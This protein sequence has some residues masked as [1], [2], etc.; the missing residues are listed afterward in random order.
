M[1]VAVISD[2]HANQ[3]ALEA[4]LAQSEMLG[5]GHLVFLGDLVGYGPDPEIVTSKVADLVAKGA[6][7]V[8]GNHDAA[9]FTPAI[10]MND[11]A[12]TAIAWTRTRLGEQSLHFLQKLPL[13]ATLDDVLLVHADASDPGRW[14]YVMDGE[15]ARRSLAA[16]AAR[17]TIC[18][19][20]HVPQLYCRTATAKVISHAPATAV[21]V[22]L[23]EQRQ[24][25]AVA[26]ACGQPR[27]GNPAAAFL[28]YDTA[29]RAL[30]CRRAPYDVEAEAQRI[31]AAGL[32]EQ[33]A[34]RLL[35]GT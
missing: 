24:W 19:H 14:N 10:R 25:L 33:L 23:S 8:L 13:T 20:V 27:D 18:G 12:N 4:C 15:A 11:I 26:G 28:T 3:L 34:K 17:I 35:T 2:I 29:T 6:T 5:V 30:T 31:R 7:A 9:I 1:L 32:P 16:T 22:T 21:P